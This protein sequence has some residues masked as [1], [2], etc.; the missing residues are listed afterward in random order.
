M[1]RD[2]RRLATT[3]L[4]GSVPLEDAATVFAQVSSHLRSHATRLPDGETGERSNWIRWQLPVL[5]ACPQL[6]VVTAESF[7]DVSSKI[8]LQ[9]SISVDDVDLGTLGYSSVAIESYSEFLKQREAGQIAAD[10]RFQVSL[11]TPLAPIQFFVSP[12]FR[13]M[14][15]P[16][17]EVALLNELSEILSTIPHEDLAIQWDTAAE[18]G[19]IEGTF[20]SYLENPLED[21]LER[22]LR[23]GNAVPDAVEL[24]YHMCYGD[25]N[26][27]HFVEPED[28]THLVAVTNGLVD[29]IDRKLDWVHLPV[30]KDRFDQAFYKPLASLRMPVDSELFLGL[31]HMSDGESGARRRIEAAR[32]YLQNFGIATE[33]GFGRRPSDTIPELLQIHATLADEIKSD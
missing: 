15:E 23:L 6:E 30:P 22:L 7:G 19:V 24:G 2:Q 21:I 12:E 28:T 13:S 29:R 17:Y 11:P 26:H 18:F 31:I 27:R 10:C 25:S 4:V 9:E 1:K 33:F 5:A 20:A 14:L 3:H 8:K 32:H 16:V